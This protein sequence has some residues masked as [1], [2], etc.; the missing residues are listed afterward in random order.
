[1]GVGRKPLQGEPTA[2]LGAQPSPALGAERPDGVAVASAAPAPRLGPGYHEQH[3]HAPQTKT[4]RTRGVKPG[5]KARTGLSVHLGRF[6][7]VRAARGT[8]RP[9]DRRGRRR[10]LVQGSLRTVLLCRG[11]TA[12]RQE[13]ERPQ[14]TAGAAHGPGAGEPGPW[15]LWAAH[16]RGAGQQAGPQAGSH[17]ARWKAPRLLT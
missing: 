6:S 8:A 11:T 10:P 13:D 2:C 14:L 7:C 9:A 5:P 4:C 15:P 3:H 1:M 16:P 17:G 12:G